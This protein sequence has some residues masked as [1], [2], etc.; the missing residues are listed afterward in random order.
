MAV[1]KPVEKPR[2]PGRPIGSKDKQPRGRPKSL[3]RVLA[4]ARAE[5]LQIYSITVDTQG[6]FTLEFEP[7]K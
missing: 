4:A 6:G 5:G 1:V 3:K 2:S 7:P